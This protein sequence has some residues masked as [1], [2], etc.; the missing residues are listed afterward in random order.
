[1]IEGRP[2]H[3][4]GSG[5]TALL[6]ALRLRV[7]LAEERDAIRCLDAATVAAAASEKEALLVDL[8]SD[9]LAERP[10]LIDELRSLIVEL[11][12]NGVLLAHARDC[13]RDA[14]TALQGDRT[15]GQTLGQ[16]RPT[17]RP[18]HHLSTTG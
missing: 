2:H 12:R 6:A 17:V 9:S 4:T 8:R 15:E 5:Q 7:L 3:P 10:V 11:R 1:M 14:I 13:V 16:V 18:G